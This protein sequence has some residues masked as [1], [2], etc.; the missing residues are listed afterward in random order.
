MIEL[1]VPYSDP[2][3]DGPV[4]QAAATRALENGAT[5][6][7][8]IAMAKKAIDNGKGVKAPIVMFTYFNPIYQRGV[9]TFVRQIADAGAKGLL[10]PD[11]PL[12]ETYETSK[13]CAKYG[14]DLVLLS[15]PTT[16]TERA[17]QIA[18]NTKGF[19]SLIHI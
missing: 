7:K 1:G 9:E 16:P 10:I 6:D 18:Q 12:E 4:I 17:R 19:L 15:T 2:L 8:V 3:A 13:I 14:I 5:L 11:V